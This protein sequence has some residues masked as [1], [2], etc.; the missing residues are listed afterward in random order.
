MDLHL[1]FEAAEISLVVKIEEEHTLNV[2]NILINKKINSILLKRDGNE[3]DNKINRSNI[4][5][6]CM[7]ELS[8]V[9]TKDFVACVPVRF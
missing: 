9:L 8:Y 3:N 5:K 2:V 7:A 1:R 6:I 4:C